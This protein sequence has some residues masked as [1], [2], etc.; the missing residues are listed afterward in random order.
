MI[1][2]RAAALVAAVLLVATG[3]PLQGA[4]ELGQRAEIRR[5]TFGV[6]HILAEDEEA[7]GF[8]FG[9]AMAEDHAEELG[10]RYLQ[11]RGE[12]ARHFG[13]AELDSDFAMR[14]FDN[15]AAARRALSDDI[16]RRF[17]QWLRGFAAGVN[18]YATA[19]PDAVPSWMPVV[20]PSDPLAYGRMFAVLAASRP[21]ARLV[22][23][24][25]GGP[26]IL[27]TSAG[28]N[29][30][31]N[32][33]ALAGSKTTSGHPILLGNPHL[34]WS[35]LYW[36]AHVTVPG[37]INFYGSTLVGI[38]VLRAGFNDRLGF[39]QTNN[40]P[41]LE[42]I[43][44]LPLVPGELDVFVHR[45]REHRVQ[46][47]T[48]TADVR[49]DDGQFVAQ[50]RD[51]EETPLGPVIHR[52]ADRLFVLRSINLEWWRQYEGFFELLDARSLDD[53]RRTL[54][55]RLGVTSNYTYA[56][57]EG[58]ILYAWN[59]R[60]PLRPDPEFDYDVDVPAESGKLFWKG[61]HRLSELPWLLNPRG[62][63]VQNANNPPW[64]T[65]LQHPLDPAEYPS[66][67]PRMVPAAML[68]A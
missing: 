47:W 52:T 64:W 14:R 58:N 26:P 25:S 46:R 68:D 17:R 33:L 56:D 24:Y 28:D 48:V 21:P 51:Y 30:G 49:Q 35:A 43:Y 18:A 62:G 45:G 23:K 65:S 60:L 3:P 9:F 50:Q 42:D 37:R 13:A 34:A 59:A 22:Q 12:A 1:G 8:A 54:G 2:A 15:R 6:P 7:A 57:V 29:A 38:P 53:F 40:A 61:I 5:D 11:A 55:R 19:Y 44:A 36:E 31:S 41:D 10:R 67:T 4:R 16:G 63:Y 20:E 66:Y 32:A 39:V 27:T